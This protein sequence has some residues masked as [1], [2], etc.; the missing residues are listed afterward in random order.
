MR[1]LFLLTA[2]LSVFLLNAQDKEKII[3]TIDGENSYDAEFIRVYQKN[4]DIVVESEKKKIEDYFELFLNFKLKLKQAHDISLD[5]SSTYISE[6]AKYKEQLISPY[7]QNP[8]ATDSLVKQA[9]NRTVNEVSASHILIKIA[10]DAIPK[11]TILAFER[12]SLARNEILKGV[13]FKDVALKFSEDPSVKINS[14]SL[15]YFSAFSMVY[16]FENTAYNTEIGETSKPFRTQFGYHLIYV[17]DKRKSLGEIQV[18]H[19]MVKSKSED[20]TYAKNKINEIYNKLEQGDDFAQIALEHS[21]DQSSAKKGGI[22]PQF[23]TGR[24]IGSFENTAFGLKNIGD[25][26]KPFQ[27]NYGWHILKLLNKY[28]VKSYDILHDKLEIK[29]KNG[30]RFKYVEKSLALKLSKNYTIVEHRE[31]LSAFYL[32]YEEKMKSDQTLMRIEDVIYTAKDFYDFKNDNKDKN[33][34]KLY[35]SFKD[36]NIIEYYKN[37]LEYT[38]KEFAVTYQEYKD[39]LLLFE[40]LQ[41]NIWDKAETDSI[42]L[43]NY[44]N[45]NI[46]KYT[47]KRRAELTIASCTNKEKAESVRKYLQ[48]GKTVSEIKELLN[49]GAL[50]HVL[51][52]SGTLEE[53]SDKLPENYLFSNGVSGIYDDNDNHFTIINVSHIIPP[54]AKKLNESRGEVIN[55]YQNY[56]ENIWVKNLREI[57]KI[58]INKKNLKKLKYQFNE[59]L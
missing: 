30:S 25:F 41:K 18:A 3:F 8:E 55:D 43:L 44:F 32:H 36:R 6:L 5:T 52:S 7:L 10:P 14:G 34:E 45:D 15:G 20:S 47:W 4:K 59:S 35:G 22:L 46:K 29:V 33:I 24:M 17:T 12:I 13:P 21:D 1:K 31:I 19:I 54:V 58:K 11:D 39:G 23:G 38:N 37:N 9:Y 2:L 48:E 16:E 28:P 50:I 56:L 26:S 42:G 53:G 27:T 57:Y 40:L 51:F 49:E